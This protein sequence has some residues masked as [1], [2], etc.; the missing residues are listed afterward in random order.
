MP[1]AKPPPSEVL[2]SSPPGT[3]R[4][5]PRRDVNWDI[6]AGSDPALGLMP[7]WVWGP[8]AVLFTLAAA[9]ISC[10][11]L[12]VNAAIVAAVLA[13]VSAGGAAWLDDDRAI[14]FFLFVGPFCLLVVQWTLIDVARRILRRK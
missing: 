7:G 14:Q 13:A 4:A 8:V 9:I 3:R 2:S 11:L 5:R 1:P 10:V 6:D 12:S